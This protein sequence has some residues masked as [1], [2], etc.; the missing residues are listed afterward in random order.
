MRHT[1]TIKFYAA[2]RDF[3]YVIADDGREIYFPGKRVLGSTVGICEHDEVTF[4]IVTDGTRVTAV[5]LVRVGNEASEAAYAAK[6]DAT[7]AHKAKRDV[8]AAAHQAAL[9]RRERIKANVAANAAKR[10]SEAH[11]RRAAAQKES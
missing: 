6:Q 10:Q 9:E 4:N 8:V 5:D 2:R 11:A 3:G 1:G 7:A